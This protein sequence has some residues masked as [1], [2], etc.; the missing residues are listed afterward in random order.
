MKD[1]EALNNYHGQ[2]GY[3]LDMVRDEL[4][5]LGFSKEEIDAGGLRVT[6]TFDQQAQDA[7]QTAATDGFPP[8][9]N[10]GVKMGL[11]SVEPD[12]GAV[13]AIYGGKNW[14]KSQ[15]NDAIGCDPGRLHD[16]GLHHRGRPAERVH[17]GEHLQRQLAVLHRGRPQT[18]V[19]PG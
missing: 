18:R 7:A 4:K 13:K 2:T 17:L 3:M 10:N 11:V 12:T 1:P 6:T 5:D 14:E 15:Y 8:E 16:Q 9:P 19:Q